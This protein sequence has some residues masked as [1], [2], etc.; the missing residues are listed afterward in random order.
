MTENEISN[1]I[2]KLMPKA[3]IVYFN[4]KTVKDRYHKEQVEYFSL[5]DIYK[6][7]ITIDFWDEKNRIL[8]LKT[9]FN[10]KKFFP[11]F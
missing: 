8:S 4:G 2:L 7:N 1:N 5:V 9:N 3:N 6:H 10:I 11:F